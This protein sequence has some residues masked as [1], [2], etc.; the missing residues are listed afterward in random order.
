MSY[1][2][3]IFGKKL[4]RELIPNQLI[5]KM[6]KQAIRIIQMINPSFNH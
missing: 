5:V 4:D 2:V 3:L 6:Q 1:Q